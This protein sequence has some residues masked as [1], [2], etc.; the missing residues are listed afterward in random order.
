MMIGDL[1]HILCIA[2]ALV[3]NESYIDI[4][5]Q[6]IEKLNSFFEGILFILFYS[7]LFLVEQE[8]I[9]GVVFLFS[10]FC[11][12]IPARPL[13]VRGNMPFLFFFQIKL[14][15]RLSKFS[16]AVGHFYNDLCAC[17]WFTYLMLFLQKVLRLNS[18][19]A[20][21]L[22]LVGQGLEKSNQSFVIYLSRR[23][24]SRNSLPTFKLFI[25]SR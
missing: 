22:M 11:L 12:V 15:F 6:Q 8:F 7:R 25:Y 4:G 9:V 14:P 1:V 21:F 20:G 24:Q 13:T 2:F 3:C 5:H 17:M 19:H 16:F 23:I 18:M 10:L